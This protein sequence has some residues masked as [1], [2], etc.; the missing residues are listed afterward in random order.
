MP[1]S[2]AEILTLISQLEKQLNSFINKNDKKS[3]S[4]NILKSIGVKLHN[5]RLLSLKNKRSY[6]KSKVFIGNQEECEKKI[7]LLMKIFMKEQLLFKWKD[8]ELI[9]QNLRE[10]ERKVYEQLC[11]HQIIFYFDFF[12]KDYEDLFINM[13]Q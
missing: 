4:I 6:I 1:N 10:D 5:F 11:K 8:K 9:I 2:S 7:I 12:S 3:A 13:V